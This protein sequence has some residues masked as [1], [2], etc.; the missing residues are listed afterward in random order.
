MGYRIVVAGATGN[1]GREVL[2]ILAEREF[3]IDE[4]AAVASSRSQG[5]DVEIGDSGRTVKCQNIDNFDWAG[6]DMAIFAIGSDATAIHAPKAAAAGCVVIDN[7]SLYRMDPDVPLIVPEVNP[8]AIDGYTKRNIIAN[9]N[10]STAQMV[11]ALKPLHDAAKIKRVVVSTY[12]SVSGA[13]KSGMDELWNQTRQIFVGDEK[14]IQKFTKQ[15][16]FNVIPHI[17]K[18]LDDGSTKEEWKMVVETKKILDPKIK[19]TATCVRVPVFVGHSEAI[20]IEMEDELSAED[21]QRILREAPGVVLH[22]KR[23]DGGYITPVECVGDF[24]TFVSRVREDPTVENGL[25]L[26]CVSDNL[27][28][29]AALNAVQI[30]ELLGRRHL[31]KG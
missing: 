16:A 23:E 2:A 12:Q 24:A 18:F 4:L 22:D 19:V 10:C 30:A 14:D 9:P 17:D 29:G 11:V 6:W 21:A 5:T 8:D 1:V 13:G 25:N 27:R 15:I 3:P 26:W 7:S 28:K 31:K 20:N